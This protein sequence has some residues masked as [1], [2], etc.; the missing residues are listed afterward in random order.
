MRSYVDLERAS[1]GGAAYRHGEDVR[2]ACSIARESNTETIYTLVHSACEG[3]SFTGEQ[4]YTELEEGGDLPD[5]YSGMLTP[6]ALR[7]AAETL[8]LMRESVTSAE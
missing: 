3:L 7:L 1:V 6:E 2:T 5:I 4:L 8:A